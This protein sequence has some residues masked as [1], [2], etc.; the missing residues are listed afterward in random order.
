MDKKRGKLRESLSLQKNTRKPFMVILQLCMS[1]SIC[2]PLLCI[3]QSISAADSRSWN[4]K[5]FWETKINSF[6][7]MW[8]WNENACVLYWSQ[9]VWRT[10]V[11]MNSL[12][13]A[14]EQGM[15]GLP[16]DVKI[17]TNLI[18][19]WLCSYNKIGLLKRTSS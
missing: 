15:A 9:Y 11:F 1:C 12:F 2:K 17:K 13:C 5:L 19:R 14:E 16:P 8:I 18:R 4:E 3:C 6:C 10:F 7:V